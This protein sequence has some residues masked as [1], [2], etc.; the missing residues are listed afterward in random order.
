MMERFDR[1][2]VCIDQVERDANIL[3]YA[4]ALGQT[5]DPREIH[6]L[7]VSVPPR[8]P[9]IASDDGMPLV[10]DLGQGP[11]PAYD[12]EQIMETLVAAS[13][14]YLGDFPEEIRYV[15]AREGFPLNEILQFASVNAIDLIIIGRN[16]GDRIERG[17][18]ALLARRVTRRS[19]CSVLTLSESYEAKF[20]RIVVPCRDS[21]CSANALTAACQI[22]ST[23]GGEVDALNVFYLYPTS[24][25]AGISMAD[26]EMMLEKHAKRECDSLL[27]R[28]DPGG[29]MVAKVCLPDPALAPVMIILSWCKESNCDLIV[30]G[31]RGRTGAAGILL[32]TVTEQLIRVSPAPVLA[33]KKKGECI[34]V[35]RALQA[36]IK[37]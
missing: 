1:I 24:Y 3:K 37:L 34:G 28:I 13:N 35:V 23:H 31:A 32:G 6:L 26:H 4:S 29:V 22:A 27:E 16:Y 20:D 18:K 25:Q 5:L 2:L 10:A 19:T 15:E 17:D 33:V 36:L 7:H 21:E 11:T 8:I 30:I 12:R 9:V 14:R